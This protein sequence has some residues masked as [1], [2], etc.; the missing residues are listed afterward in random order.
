MV[1]RGSGAP[2]TPCR[3]SLVLAKEEIG[4]EADGVEK[5]VSLCAE[6]A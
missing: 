4:A 2:F 6:G 3:H 5:V 1:D